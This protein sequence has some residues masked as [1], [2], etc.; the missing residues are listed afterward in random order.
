MEPMGQND[1]PV[2]IPRLQRQYQM[3][4][5]ILAFPFNRKLQQIIFCRQPPWIGI[6]LVANAAA[7]APTT[8]SASTNEL[9]LVSF[10]RRCGYFGFPSSCEEKCSGNFSSPS[11]GSA[12]FGSA[13]F[14]L[15]SRPT[16]ASVISATKIVPERCPPRRL[17]CLAVSGGG[18][19]MVNLASMSTNRRTS[20]TAHN[21]PA[22]GR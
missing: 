17:N 10:Q 11:F 2:P 13:C 14:S 18:S 5:A 4:S 1:F 16:K 9:M 6:K 8:S 7:E 3:V 21:R 12:A 22:E 15:S 19:L 20:S